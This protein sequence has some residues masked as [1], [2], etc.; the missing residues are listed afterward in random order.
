MSLLMHESPVVYV[1]E[2]LPS[3]ANFRKHPTRPLN[4][5]ESRAL[6]ELIAGKDLEIDQDSQSMQMLGAIRASESCTDCHDARID[7]LLGAFSYRLRLVT[8]KK[9]R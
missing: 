4:T 2:T 5:F 6:S 7:D 1:T 3:M 8:S 9:A